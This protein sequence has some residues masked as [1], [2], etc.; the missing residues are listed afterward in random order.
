VYLF[1]SLSELLCESKHCLSELLHQSQV[2]KLILRE[3]ELSLSELRDPLLD[4]EPD[5]FVC[6]ECYPSACSSVL[7][8]AAS[9]C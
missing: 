1:K 9:V 3:S 6:F 8:D 5:T 2:F 7:V 4:T